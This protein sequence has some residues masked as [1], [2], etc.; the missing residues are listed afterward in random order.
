MP[1][2]L[3]EQCF[4]YKAPDPVLEFD[5][6][7]PDGEEYRALRKLLET[8]FREAG[9]VIRDQDLTVR[10]FLSVV[11]GLYCTTRNSRNLPGAAEACTRF[12]HAAY[13]IL[14]QLVEE[15]VPFMWTAVHNA[16]IGPLVAESR[17]DTR[18]LCAKVVREITANEKS[19]IRLVV[20]AVEPQTRR[21]E[22]D[23]GS[24]PMVRVGTANE[25]DG[26]TWLSWGVD[27]WDGAEQG[28]EYPVYVQSHALRNIRDR[29][30]LP[31]MGPYLECWL[32]DSLKHPLIVERQGEDLLVE[33]RIHEDRIGYLVCT[34][35]RDLSRQ[36]GLIAV[37]T[38]KFLTM[39]NTPEARMLKTQ[40]RLSR[41]DVDWLGLHEL[42]AFTQTDL[43]DDPVLREMMAK[44]GCGHLFELAV[45][46]EGSFVPQAKPFAA[47]MRKYLR[48]AA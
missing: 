32:Y 27:E 35:V 41:R 21:V 34:P 22:L 14:N 24:R 1:R 31:G 45:Q 36:G 2:R 46:E 25:W 10:D 19:L 39:E 6:T 28:K 30:N 9:L 11:V 44:C 3:Q 13:P 7:F 40:L 42:A 17:M 38:F 15:G 23:G 29:A 8:Q 18:L 37:R 33:F 16:V 5:A 48:I 20:S 4:Q 26:V 47:E 12:M 43:R